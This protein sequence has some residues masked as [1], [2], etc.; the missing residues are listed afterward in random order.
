MGPFKYCQVHFNIGASEV[1]VTISE[2][3]GYELDGLAKSIIGT[4]PRMVEWR[5]GEAERIMEGD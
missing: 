1:K 2:I 5:I 4:F 3:Y